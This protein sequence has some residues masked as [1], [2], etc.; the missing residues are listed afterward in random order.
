[1]G[2]TDTDKIAVQCCAND[3]SSAARPG[4]VEGVTFAFAE[5]H[6]ESEGLRLCTMD[7]VLADMGRK[8]GC[9]FSDDHVWTS[10]VCSSAAASVPLF[11][12]PESPTANKNV[13]VIDLRSLPST[14]AWATSLLVSL[15]V[16]AVC[17]VYK[18][19]KSSARTTYA[20]VQIA[21]IELV[22]DE[23]Q[24]LNA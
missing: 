17:V 14:N 9:G 1:M 4:C 10:T 24:A 20:K 21:D 8:K 5:R 11:V 18:K 13:W 7:E 15:L 2:D 23:D 16:L 6:C 22:T 19:R 3:G 12:N